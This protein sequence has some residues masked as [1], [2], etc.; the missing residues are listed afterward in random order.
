[1]LGFADV[2]DFI[3]CGLE[4][5]PQQVVWAVGGRQRTRPN[6]PILYE[7]AIELGKHG[8]DQKSQAFKD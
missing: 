4:L 2:G 1:M 3:E 6:E 8:G 7:W 5:D